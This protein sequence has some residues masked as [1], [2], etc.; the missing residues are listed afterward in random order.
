MFPSM[1]LHNAPIQININSAIPVIQQF[2]H[3]SLRPL[4]PHTT[5]PNKKKNLE[6]SVQKRTY[7][8]ANMQTREF[9][10]VK[11]SVVKK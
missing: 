10:P 7:P 11:K 9:H 3:G 5:H 2:Y 4:K 8:Q 1:Q 6:K